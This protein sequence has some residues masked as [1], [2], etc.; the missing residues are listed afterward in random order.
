MLLK[1]LIRESTTNDAISNGRPATVGVAR[2]VS[3]KIYN[4]LVSTVSTS[5]PIATV[6]AIQQLIDGTGVLDKD[7]IIASD[8][9]RDDGVPALE[10]LL[11]TTIEIGSLFCHE[12]TTYKAL[13]PIVVGDTVPS[14]STV[15]KW[16]FDGSA[17]VVNNTANMVREGSFVINRIQAAVDSHTVSIPASIELLTD[18]DRSGVSGLSSDEVISDLV[19]TTV[20]EGINRDVI[21]TLVAIAKTDPAIVC[22]DNQYE[23]PRQLITQANRMAAQILIDTRTPATFILCSPKVAASLKSSGQEIELDVVTDPNAVVNYMV[24]GAAHDADQPSAL[25]YCPLVTDEGSTTLLFTGDPLSLNPNYG[26]INRYAL[27][28]A[29][30]LNGLTD[31]AAVRSHTR[32]SFV[33]QSQLSRKCLVTFVK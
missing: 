26:A 28:I 29:P 2:K 17:V 9:T 5:Q 3:S 24:V 32:E 25:Y 4:S 8:G 21:D 18:L 13:N 16:L 10:E 30:D 6:F 20:A 12:S 31:N 19:A 1:R 7:S 27:V 33:G 15:F 14:D 23:Q 11:D 22:I